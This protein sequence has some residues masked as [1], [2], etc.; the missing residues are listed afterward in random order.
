MV[1]IKVFIKEKI[2][3]FQ[4]LFQLSL[5]ITINSFMHQFKILSVFKYI[6]C[7]KYYNYF[8]YICLVFT[9]VLLSL[10]IKN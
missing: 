6:F 2:A 4:D 5:F 10:L 3:I 8:V 7:F 9:A 1:E